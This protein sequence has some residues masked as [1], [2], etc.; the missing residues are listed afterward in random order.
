M[1]K[2]IL[3]L[4]LT[5]NILVK[6][7]R[8]SFT[9]FG[10]SDVVL[11]GPSPVATW[12]L[13]VGRNL[14]PALSY[15][16]INIDAS[17]VLDMK[18]SFLTFVVWDKPVLSVRLSQVE[19]QIRIPLD[20]VDFGFSDFIKLEVYGSLKISDDRCKDI[21][22]GG[23]YVTIEKTSYIEAFYFAGKKMRPGIYDYIDYFNAGGFIIIPDSLSVAEIEG[24]IW[25]YSFLR[26]KTG[27]DFGLATFK[28][29]PDT[30]TNL[31]IISRFDKLPE[32]FKNLINGKF[33]KD[34]GLLYLFTSKEGKIERK[35]LFLIGFSDEGLRKALK[36]FLN[37][38]VISS[39]FNSFLLV[40]EAVELPSLKPLLP[41]FK[42]SFKDLGFS[43]T[44]LEG[45]GN[46]GMNYSFRLSDF[47][48]LPNEIEFNISAVYSPVIKREERAFFNV[49]FNGTL[50]ESKRLSEEGRV[51]YKFKVDRFNL[52]KV[53]TIRIEF[54][55]YPSSEECKNSLFKFFAK[56]DD[57]N[58]F[59]EVK[60]SYK[61]DELSFQYFPGVFGYGE[62]VAIISKKITI[63]KME[64]L[65]RIIYVVNAGLKNMYFYPAVVYSDLVDEEILKNFNIVGVVDQ[66]DKLFEKFDKIPLKPKQEFRI[67]SAGTARVLY[68]LWDTT[69]IGVVQIFYGYGDNSVVL[70][71]GMGSNADR[72]ALDVAK[73][74][75]KNYDLISGNIGIADYEKEYFFRIESRLVRVQYAGEKTFIDYFN[76]YKVFII[77]L[78]WFIVLAFF[79]YIFI[80][81]K[82]HA[83]RVTKR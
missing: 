73:A 83:K 44:R 6:S 20:K 48:V 28:T 5:L 82:Q 58:S 74:V 51:N 9:K 47:G 25:V 72:R 59:I 27:S 30:T 29:L 69:S 8:I 71:T 18:N 49:Y 34:D 57:D 81:G 17:P 77:G 75:E 43:S 41:P 31:V 68:A 35:I 65:A 50:V 80:R 1:L 79:V 26:E 37:P 11:Q 22:S 2:R 55:F 40:R 24:Y 15:I 19:R 45:I 52:M 54:V 32:G 10:Y 56:V 33:L 42:I 76:E 63:E 21:E 53:N 66:D 36:A 62:T 70:I 13:K 78:V 14:N 16:L 61:P 46:L 67:I 60:E 12:F 38:D 7:E 39:S 3:I 23:L 4:M 64:A